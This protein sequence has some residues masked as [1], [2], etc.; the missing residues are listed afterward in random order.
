[1]TDRLPA[2]DE[3]LRQAAT[4]LRDG[5][6][7][8]FP[9]DTVYGVGCAAARPDAVAAIFA[10]KR[11]PV[12]RLIPIL[13]SGLRDV[14]PEDWDVDERAKS[15]TEA[16]WPGALTL[17]LPSRD[18]GRSQA[19]RAPDHPVALALIEAAGPLY[20]TSANVS[21]EPETLDA[22]D[23]LI[24]FATRADELAAVVD[25][26]RVSGGIASTVLDLT[27]GP[28]RVIREGPISRDAITAIV[29]LQ[30]VD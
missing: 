26:G 4:I 25:G 21:D 6:L 27:V 1:M 20:V 24:A 22:D 5:G 18:R 17:V 30:H 15:L 19:F 28:P 12:D 29:D 9:T 7:V 23:V 3:G 13:L 11:R 8:A 2:T 16:F 14:S 10:L